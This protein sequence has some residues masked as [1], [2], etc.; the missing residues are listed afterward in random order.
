[1]SRPSTAE[2][3]R[4]SSSCTAGS[5]RPPTRRSSG[6]IDGVQVVYKPIAGERPL[7]DFPDGTLADR[8]VAAYLVSRGHS[9][10]TSCRTTWLR[11]GP[12]G[13]GMVQLWQEP[14]AE[15]E[16][17]TLVRGG[18]GAARAA[19]TSSTASTAA[20]SRCRWCTRTPPPLRRMAVFDIVVNN[21]DRKGGHVL[22]MADGHRYGVDHGV[23]FHT[24]H[25]LRTVLWGWLG[26]P[27][28][29]EE[30]GRGASGCA[31]RWAASSGDLLAGHLTDLEIDVRRPPLRP[32][33][34]QRAPCPRRA[35]SGPRS[36]GRPSDGAD[37]PVR[38]PACVRGLPRRFPTLPVTGPAV[39]VH[40]TATG[41]RVTTP[42]DGAGPALRLRH[43]AVRRHAHG[44]RRD[45]RRLRPAATGPGA[46]P[47]T[48][49][50][51]SRTSPTST[52]RCSSG[53][54][55]SSVDWARARRA[56]DRAVPPGHDRAAGAA[57]RALRRRRRV[58]PAR[59]R[60][61]RAA[62]G[63]RLGLPR[64]G[65]PLLLGHRRPGVRRGVG[66]DREEMLRIF[67]E[68]GG[69]PDRP[70]KKDPLD[71]VVWRGRA[72][73]ASRRWDEPVRARPSRLAH[74]VHRDRAGAPRRRVRR[75]GRRQRPG[76]PA[77]RDV[78]RP[79]A[80]RRRPAR[81][82]R[83]PT[84]TP[85]WSPT[86]ARRCRSRGATWSSS[87]RCATATSTRWRSGWSLLRHH[88]RSDWEWTDDQLWDAV[89]TLDALAPGPRARRRRTGRAGRRR[90]ARGAGRR[91]RRAACGGRRRA[92]GGRHP[93]HRRARPTP[94]TRGGGRPCATLLDAALG[95][96]LP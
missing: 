48:T 3:A 89:D 20:T 23:T 66:L 95:L 1:M 6:E 2:L 16:A 84:R 50:P 78:R 93:R 72:R 11:D 13:P 68:R 77:P 88:Y 33:A 32:A 81:R 9:A 18:R 36:R 67:P 4:A 19:S 46:T 21:A 92:L 59:D 34:G 58:D 8:E 91:P 56:R 43:H 30:A 45:V 65:R 73:R 38:L 51:T 83:R 25:K 10:G 60:P 85:A 94:A 96:A 31:R 82:S 87:P 47:A 57:A 90:G 7:W 71:C 55:R 28:T 69:D 63:G 27:L 64:R 79:R 62:A 86:T 15:Q 41:G 29:D 35:A 70:G 40:D 44:P 26:E 75:P 24:D 61:D 52:T 53:P 14:D 12:H 39:E 80:G 74:R 54:R 17:V 22:E 76:L 5:C 37:R 42:P 49:S